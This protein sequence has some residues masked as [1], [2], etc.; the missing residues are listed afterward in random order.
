MA[1]PM[2]RIICCLCGK[3]I[4]RRSDAYDLDK[5]WQRRLPQMNGTIACG[6]ALGISW[7]CRRPGGAD[8][9]QVQALLGHA[10][11]DTSA[12]YFRA[13][14]AEQAAVVDRVFT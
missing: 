14:T 4:P 3:L 2:F 11:L 13:G 8:V 5:E 7:Q 6:C 12:R 9:A 1:R 10:S